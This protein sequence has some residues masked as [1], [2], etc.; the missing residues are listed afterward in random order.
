MGGRLP[1]PARAVL[2]LAALLAGCQRDDLSLD[3]EAPVEISSPAPVGS[4]EPSLASDERGGVYL[5]W[6]EADGDS[7]HA[8]RFSRLAGE[9]WEEPRTIA[10]GSHWFVNWADVPSVVALP[11][12]RLAAHYLVR[13]PHGKKRYHYGI[14]VVQ[15]A[16]GGA[17]WSAP[18]VPHRDTASAEHGFVSLFAAEGDSLG[19]VW[20]DGRKY[21]PAYGGTEETTL[22][23]TTLAAD[24]GLGAD[25]A[26]DGRICDC[27]QTAHAQSAEGPLVVYRDRSPDD[28]RDIAVV[29]R[30][31]GRWTEGR[32]VHADGWQISACPVNGPAVA[33]LGE[34]VAVAWF[35][36][37]GDTARVLVAFSEDAGARFGEPIRVDGGDPAGR[38]D[39]ELLPNGTA[40]VGWLE[41]TDTAGAEVRARMVTS[42]GEMGTTR[43]IAL[44]SGERSSGFP[45]LARSGDALVVAWTEAGERP[46]V[47]TARI[48]A[49]GGS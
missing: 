25:S 9:R 39:V 46:R 14:R 49:G 5:S 23:F 26:L 2:A 6:I 35:T 41:R 22:R 10:R 43:T 1:H 47:R 37:A 45:R 31:N 18:V 34:R 20:L 13:D 3:L 12:G 11:G 19:M 32:T 33:A 8:L 17:T 7:A 36:A 15:S 29:R 28:V 42:G 16:D 44:S 24:G 4:A 38:V 21:S 40:V 30:V 27:C 48:R